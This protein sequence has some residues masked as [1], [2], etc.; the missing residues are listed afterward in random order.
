MCTI[1][2]IYCSLSTTHSF[3]ACITGDCT[4]SC[5]LWCANNDF[6]LKCL[7]GS[8]TLTAPDVH[9]EH[10]NTTNAESSSVEI[11]YPEHFLQHIYRMRQWPLSKPS[12]HKWPQ[13]LRLMKFRDL[14]SLWQEAIC[15]VTPVWYPPWVCFQ[16]MGLI[17]GSTDTF[18]KTHVRFVFFKHLDQSRC[19]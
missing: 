16:D 9:E 8:G 2:C 3:K 14:M 10:W 15:L 7:G 18:C 13:H 19:T 12:T 5:G 1:L 11:F 17:V 6:M 4:D